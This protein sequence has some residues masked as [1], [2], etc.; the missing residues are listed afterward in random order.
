M[1][2]Q[3]LEQLEKKRYSTPNSQ[4]RAHVKHHGVS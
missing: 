1:I 2:E 4:I 3:V